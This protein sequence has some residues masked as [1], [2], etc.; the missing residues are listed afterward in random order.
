MRLLDTDVMIDILRGYLPAVNWL[1]GLLE[2]PGLPGFVVME[3]ISGCPNKAEVKK[4]QKSLLD[5]F[6]KYKLNNGL[7]IM[8]ALIGECAVGLGATLSTFNLKHFKVIPSLK[9]EQ[10]YTKS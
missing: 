8:D 9:T 7:G 3:L 5:V 10:P 1:A 2:V 4:L 6:V